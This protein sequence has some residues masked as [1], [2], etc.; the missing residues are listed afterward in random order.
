MSSV[1]RKV[2]IKK[3]PSM[4]QQIHSRI[5]LQ[6][7]H[8]PVRVGPEEGHEIIRG[9]EHLS[10]EERL[11]EL[12]LFSLEKRRLQGD[13]IATFP[14]LKGAYKK[15]GERLFTG[16]CSDRTRGNIFKLKESRFRLDIWKKSFMVRVLRHWNRLLRE[17]MEA[18]SLVVFKI[19]SDRSLSNL[20]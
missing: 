2:S 4:S 7:R 20:I 1:T 10:F 9:L 5:F 19:R 15:D 16:A 13:L 18:P 6:E 12:L 14:Y 8:G 11:S 3:N 17:A